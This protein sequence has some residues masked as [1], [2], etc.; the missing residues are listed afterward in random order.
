MSEFDPIIIQTRKNLFIVKKDFD[1][2]YGEKFS[3]LREAQTH[4]MRKFKKPCRVR[5][6][7]PCAC[8]HKSLKKRRSGKRKGNTADGLK[9]Y[10]GEKAGKLSIFP[11]LRKPTTKTHG[12]KFDSVSPP[13][14]TF[15]KARF[16]LD[17][18]R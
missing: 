9:W 8:K 10:I 2:I 15:K 18:L 13:F 14:K 12:R 4:C 16:A 7:N 5:K 3:T 17:K 11:S 6:L 1:D